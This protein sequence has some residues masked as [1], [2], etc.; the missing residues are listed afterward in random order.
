VDTKK[1]WT[2]PASSADFLDWRSQSRVFENLCAWTGWNFNLTGGERP[3]RI[4]GARVSADFFR[5]LGAQPI[6]GRAFQPDEDQP[7][8][9]RVAL[10]SYG[11]WHDRFHADPRLLDQI[12]HLDGEPYTIIGVMPEDFH[13]T[14]MG[15][16]NIWVPLA[17]TDKERADRL[18]GWLN[19]AG[20]LKPG[21]TQ[22][23]AQQDMDAIA[24]RIEKAYPASNTNSGVLMNSLAAEI[25]KHVGAQG[26]YMGFCVC[27]CILLIACANVAGILLAWALARRS[28]MAVRLTLGAGRAVLLRQ[29]LTENLLLFVAGAGMGIVLAAWGGNW[30]TSA[31]PFENRGYLPNYGRLSLDFATLGFALGVSVL[32]GL[33][34]SLAPALESWSLNLAGTLK[35]GGGAVSVSRRGRRF[36]KILVVSEIALAMM[37]LIPAGLLAKALGSLSAADP[38]F[39]PD[40]VLTAQLHL[41]TAAYPEPAQAVQFYDQLLVRLRALPQVTTVAASRFIPFGHEG[42]AAELYIESAPAPKAG[43]IPATQITSVSSDY[44]SAVGMELVRGRFVSGQDGPKTLPVIVIN[45]T[46]AR[47]FFPDQDPLGHRLRLERTPD[48]W[49]TIV[50]VVKDVKISRMADSREPQTYVPLAQV[51]SRSV[52]VVLR[53]AGDA[54]AMGS[55]LRESI[56]AL[57]P[58]QPISDVTSLRQL[59]DEQ[60]A[61]LRVF[62]QF[63]AGFGMLALFL[64]AIGIYGIMSCVVA[65]RTREIGIRM[66]L[67][68][69]SRSVLALIVA[70]GARLTLVGLAIGLAGSVALS[71]VLAGALFGVKPNDPVTY[72]AA[73]AALT[74]AILLANLIPAR[75]AMS[76]DPLVALR[77]E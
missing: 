60:E 46:L 14:L 61:P 16:A 55:A 66:A 44:L 12:I 49:R 64:A 21:V 56:W 28:E 30:V 73:V 50:G 53:T 1:G 67:G 5:M 31:I 45:E 54:A 11:L 25:G 23:Q 2:V 6:I 57:D 42:A 24:L 37:V 32:T 69:Q 38:G 4:L 40:H 13:L 65:G 22:Q 29:L 48:T 27:I 76:V 15:R 36:R 71:E 77:H 70:D 68:A 17:L 75:Q 43:N 34:F 63:M 7:G 9:G 3:Q 41:T 47:R 20:R 35:D 10:L 58:D 74:A 72:L 39:R 59:M 18:N 26:V 62:A 33:L 51:P 8:T 52:A 19:V